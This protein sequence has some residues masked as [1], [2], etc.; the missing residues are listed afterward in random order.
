[1][2]HYR[3]DRTIKYE[4]VME[5]WEIREF[6]LAALWEQIRC[7]KGVWLRLLLILVA[8]LFLVPEAAALIAVMV[9]VMFIVS[10]IYQYVITARVLEG[11]PWCIWI[12]GDKFKAERGDS[13]EVSCRNIQFIRITRHLLMLGYLQSVKRPA[14]FIVPLRVFGNE[15]EREAFLNRIRHPQ[16]EGAENADEAESTSDSSTAAGRNPGQAAPQEYMGFSYILDGERWVRFQKGAA[17]ILNSASLGKPGRLYGMMVWGLLVA[18]VMTVCVYFAAGTFNVLLLGFCISMTVWMVLRLYCRNP[19][20]ALRKQLKSPEIAQKVCGFWQVTLTQEGI[21]VGMPMDMKS[22]YPWKSL[23]WLGEKEE[24][25]Y[26]FHQD[27]RH[28]IM[29]AKE[30]FVSWAQV[31]AFHQICADKGIE[32]RAPGKAVYVPVWLT[33]VIFGLIMAVS[34]IIFILH[35]FLFT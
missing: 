33:W 23:A 14:W 5:P 16:A 9:V 26:I 27:K 30:C 28:Y 20:K 8:E 25:F 2:E 15:N 24:A 12:E 32:K 29:I 21:A 35:L 6:C 4:Y 11:R 34:L 31:D 10:G 13:S 19:E 7:R 17:D 22:F 3:D 1:M 18:V